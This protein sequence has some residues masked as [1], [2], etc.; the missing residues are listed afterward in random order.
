MKKLLAGYQ[1]FR[2]TVWPAQHNL[3]ESLAANGQNPRALVISCIDSRV[4]PVLIFNAD[5]GDMLVVRNVANLVPPYEPDAAYHG[6]SAALEFGIRVLR[7]PNIIV[8]GHALC[9]GV[10]SLLDSHTSPEHHDFIGHWMSMA[11][12]ARALAQNCSPEGKQRC[13]EHEVIKISLANLV[14]FPWIAEPV[15]RGRLA[16]HGAWF[17]IETGELAMLGPD[18]MFGKPKSA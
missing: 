7:I 5:P 6:T 14:T 13:C 10:K 4:D 9:G 16:L 3:F 17:D 2:N 11:E 15:S 1:H 8:L 18:G 12:P